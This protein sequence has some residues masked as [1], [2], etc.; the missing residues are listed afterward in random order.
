MATA[1]MI[2]VQLLK[3]GIGYDK[4]QKD[5]L[6]GLGLRKRHKI[7]ELKDTP[8]IRGMVYKVRHLVKVL[9][10]NEL[11]AKPSPYKGA[12]IV[13]GPKTEPKAKKEAKAGKKSGAKGAKKSA[14]SS[15]KKD[16]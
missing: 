8:A 2:R 11:V 6:R 9:G 3:S 16:K 12:V 1:G 10:A 14:A 5:T 7:V 13:P 15:K 4:T